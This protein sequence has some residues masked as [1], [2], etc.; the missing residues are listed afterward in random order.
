MEGGGVEKNMLA[1]LELCI[2]IINEEV[3][4]S[5]RFSLK[6]QLSLQFI[7][8]FCYAKEQKAEG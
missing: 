4:N 6:K 3:V 8:F 1:Y 5:K 2:K 7:M